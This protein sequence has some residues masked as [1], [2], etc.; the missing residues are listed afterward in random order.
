MSESPNLSFLKKNL[1]ILVF[2]VKSYKS[3][4]LFNTLVILG[5]AFAKKQKMNTFEKFLMILFFHVQRYLK[6]NTSLGFKIGLFYPY[7]YS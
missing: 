7:P 3:E 6:I 5:N 2:N 1:R 4:E